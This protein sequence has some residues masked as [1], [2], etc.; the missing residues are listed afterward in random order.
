ME[1]L[2]SKKLDFMVIYVK[3]HQD[4]NGPVASMSF[5]RC[6]NVEAD[7]LAMEFLQENDTRRPIVLLFQSAKSAKCQLIVV[8][9]K[10]LQSIASL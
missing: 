8:M 10:I 1:S 3:I 7:R 6:L 9:R 2:I 4:D 5:K